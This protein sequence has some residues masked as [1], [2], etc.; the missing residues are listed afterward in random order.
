[1]AASCTWSLKVSLTITPRPQSPSVDAASLRSIA[2]VLYAENKSNV[3][4]RALRSHSIKVTSRR[5]GD[6]TRRC[7]KTA[8]PDCPQI[9][10]P[11]SVAA[12]TIWDPSYA[13]SAGIDISIPVT[14][15]S[16]SFHQCDR[17]IHNPQG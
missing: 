11:I 16:G 12:P 3:M 13:R 6:V 10:A 9:C 7:E 1:M 17:H 2:V 14:H 8:S 4:V 15:S 5:S